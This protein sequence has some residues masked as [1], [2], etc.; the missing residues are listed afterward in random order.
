MKN[1]NYCWEILL[2]VSLGI[3]LVLSFLQFKVKF[4]WDPIKE[5]EEISR[6]TNNS[7]SILVK[8]ESIKLQDSMRV[9][10]NESKCIEVVIEPENASDKRIEWIS[11]TTV[12]KV[13]A[14]GIVTVIDS[15]N[16][17]TIYARAMDGSNSN[18]EI[19]IIVNN[20]KFTSNKSDDIETQIITPLPDKVKIRSIELKE[21]NVNLKVGE[22]VRIRPTILPENASN[23]TV[24]WESSNNEIARVDDGTIVGVKHG[25]C[26][27][28]VSSEDGSQISNRINV[29]IDQEV[30]ITDIKTERGNIE[31][32]V[33]ETARLFPSIIPT[34]AS[35]K[36]LLWESSNS[37]IA[38]VNNGIVEGIRNG[39]CIVTVSSTDGSNKS[40]QISIHVIKQE[41]TIVFK[42]AALYNKDSREITIT[43]Q[44]ELDLQKIDD[45]T[46]ILNP[47]DKILNAKVV[48]GYLK[49][50]EFLQNG[51]ITFIDGL[52]SKL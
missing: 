13:D 37:H 32:R 19:K 17:T 39:T 18:A 33:G 26:V 22:S 12:A 15:V 51:K 3:L 25:R 38:T 10:I 16:S 21:T 36:R 9:N 42:G 34:N 28:S 4:G 30:K 35:N 20:N 1:E 27:I 7:N 24:K 2:K 48:N 43:N 50:G 6:N 11:D 31:I 23:K 49:Q 8:V 5:L 29:K 44:M 41:Q 47:G 52:N 40:S 45:S 46:L 14:N